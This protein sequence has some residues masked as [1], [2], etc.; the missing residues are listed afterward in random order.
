MGLSGLFGYGESELDPAVQAEIQF[1][2]ARA[3]ARLAIWALLV[4]F[5]VGLWYQF[6]GP[7]FTG[8]T[9]VALVTVVPF[10]VDAQIRRSTAKRLAGIGPRPPRRMT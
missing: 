9:L 1:E 5:G 8:A 7:E 10:L 4:T 3:E 2:T 6:R